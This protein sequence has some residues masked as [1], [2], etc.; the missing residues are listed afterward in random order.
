MQPLWKSFAYFPHQEEG[1]EWMLEKERKGTL[2]P[3]KDSS[4]YKTVYGGLQCD[5]MGLGKTIQITS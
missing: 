1:I 4:A 5:D 2:V 3:N